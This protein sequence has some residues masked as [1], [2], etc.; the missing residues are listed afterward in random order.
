[1]NYGVEGLESGWTSENRSE[2]M[3]GLAAME[4]H[5]GLLSCVIELDDCSAAP[6]ATP[7]NHVP[8]PKS[9]LLTLL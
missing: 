6:N 5:I 3:T 8:V 9:E 2:L 1:M 7:K 4:G